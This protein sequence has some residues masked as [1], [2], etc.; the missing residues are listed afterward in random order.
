ML[1]CRGDPKAQGLSL[2]AGTWPCKVG[3]VFSA[4]ASSPVTFWYPFVDSLV[5][6][7]DVP[8]LSWKELPLFVFLSF[9]PQCDQTYLLWE[10]YPDLDTVLR[11]YLHDK[12]LSIVLKDCELQSHSH[13]CHP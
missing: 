10:T 11:P 7:G 13:G 8:S 1:L 12:V 2:A 4:L 5:L 9:L 6:N 3:K